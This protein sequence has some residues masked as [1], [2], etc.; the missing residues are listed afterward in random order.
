MAAMSEE[1]G[2]PDGTIKRSAP[3]WRSQ[4]LND[5]LQLL[6]GHADAHLKS[7]RK[8]RIEGSPIKLP[9]PT[10]CPQWMVAPANEENIE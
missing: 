2:M 4:E 5:L 3:S 10:K 8:Q 7:T 9:P 6:D 1:E